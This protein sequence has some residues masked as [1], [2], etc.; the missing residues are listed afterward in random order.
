MTFKEGEKLIL[1][2]A[3]E[4]SIKEGDTVSLFKRENNE[5]VKFLTLV[6]NSQGGKFTLYT[7]REIIFNLGD[8]MKFIDQETLMFN[9]GLASFTKE[10]EVSF[11]L[12][13]GKRKWTTSELREILVVNGM[14]HTGFVAIEVQFTGE[15]RKEITV[16]NGTLSLNEK[17]KIIFNE[18]SS[19]NPAYI[20]NIGWT[21]ENKFTERFICNRNLF[22]R[23]EGDIPSPT[24]TVNLTLGK[25]LLLII[26]HPLLQFTI[27]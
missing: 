27:H 16:E 20:E 8:T 10:K 12:T 24:K 23:I 2:G 5:E 13:S 21:V 6:V 14:T 1:G 4:V 18:V 25:D 3:I 9:N 19:R 11:V 15:T 7:G 17:G 26:Y 22:L